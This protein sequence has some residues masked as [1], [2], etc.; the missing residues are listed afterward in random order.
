MKRTLSLTA[1]ALTAATA[2]SAMVTDT[3]RE[4]VDHYAG[5]HDVSV[6]SDAQV[7][8]L[9]NVISGG[10]GEGQKRAHVQWIIEKNGG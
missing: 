4:I 2:A 7:L 1:I 5:D 10:D 8:G 9:L 6:L 3:Q